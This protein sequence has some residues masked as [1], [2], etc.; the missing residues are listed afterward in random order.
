MTQSINGVSTE[1]GQCTQCT[2]TT[3][4]QSKRRIL[5]KITYR[6]ITDW[7]AGTNLAD[8]YLHHFNTFPESHNQ[9]V[10]KHRSVSFFGWWKRLGSIQEISFELKF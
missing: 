3:V 1:R 2:T 7:N 4:L 8:I 9:F 5:G 10:A 6:K